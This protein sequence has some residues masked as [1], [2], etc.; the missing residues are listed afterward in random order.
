MA[1]LLK[2]PKQW[3]YLSVIGILF[4][5]ISLSQIASWAF[6]PALSAGCIL[7]VMNAFLGYIVIEQGFQ[8]NDRQFIIVSLGGFVIRFFLMIVAIAL[9]LIVT[10]VNVPAFL[11]SLFAFYIFFM[12]G[13]VLHINKKIEL[14]KL[15]K[16]YARINS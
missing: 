12:I 1:I 7:S 5:L 16:S 10:K 11:L 8:L 9:V 13:E 14:M 3:L 6:I 15:R 2:L 4:T